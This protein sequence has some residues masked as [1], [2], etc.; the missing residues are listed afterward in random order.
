MFLLYG[1]FDSLI[2]P[3]HK[4]VNAFRIWRRQFPEEEPV[5]RPVEVQVASFV[6]RLRIRK[7]AGGRHRNLRMGSIFITV[8]LAPRVLLS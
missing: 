8:A 2:E 6:D 3:G 4:S 1:L 7:R 5:I